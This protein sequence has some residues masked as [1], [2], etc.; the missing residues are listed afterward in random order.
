MFERGHINS[1]FKRVA[2]SWLFLGLI[3]PMSALSTS[4]QALTLVP[5]FD[6]SVTS[7]PNALAIEN[8]VKTVSAE[9]G[10]A[11]S[12][13]A[14]VRFSVSWGSVQGSPIPGNEVASSIE[15]LSGPYSFSTLTTDI[16]TMAAANPANPV[17]Q[18]VVAHLPRS[19]PAGGLGFAIPYAEAQAIGLLPPASHLAAGGIG[20][21]TSVSWDFNPVGGVSANTYDLEG[22]ATH[23]IIEVLGRISGLESSRPTVATPLDLFRYSASGVSSFSYSAPA[24]FSID[25]G[26]TAVERF[27]VAG[28]GDRSDIASAPGLTD[29]QAA[30]LPRGIALTLSAADLTVLDALGWGAFTPPTFEGSVDPFYLGSVQS[31]GGAVPEPDLWVLMLTGFAGVGF[32]ARSVQRRPVDQPS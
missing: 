5:L 11:F 3:A 29:V 25:G 10:S 27:N 12:N 26:R 21:S 22:A 23:E 15:N 13:H 20:F 30:Y 6:S 2:H 32:A 8:A 24:Y 16:R 4:A 18:S 7:N 1:I 31:F 14:T 28:S 19:N 9:L 17:L